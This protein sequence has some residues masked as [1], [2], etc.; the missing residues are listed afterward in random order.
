MPVVEEIEQ[1]IEILST[2]APLLREA[3]MNIILLEKEL[4]AGKPANTFSRE[5]AEKE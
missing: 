2:T 3:R 4:K 1:K 5:L